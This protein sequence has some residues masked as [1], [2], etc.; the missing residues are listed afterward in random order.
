M[1]LTG[2]QYHVK[3]DK[4]FVNVLTIGNLSSLHWIESPLK[5]FSSADHPD[6][7]LCRVHYAALNFR[8]VMLATGKLP[9][10]AIPGMCNASGSYD[11]LLA[12]QSSSNTQMDDG[13]ADCWFRVSASP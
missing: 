1:L 7:Q 9:P 10:D 3:T 6:Q 8:D 5:Y 2:Q 4:A 13:L 11:N 12:S